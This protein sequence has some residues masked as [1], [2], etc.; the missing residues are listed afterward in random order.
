TGGRLRG[1]FEA[2]VAGKPGGP[3]GEFRLEPGARLGP[4]EVVQPVGA[5]GMGEVYSASDTRLGRVVALKVLPARLM[6][7]A[8]I[9]HRFEAEARTIS[10]LNHPNICKLYD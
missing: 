2:A 5:G 4:Y 3:G 10:N 1:A 8:G 6:E 9:R 7:Q